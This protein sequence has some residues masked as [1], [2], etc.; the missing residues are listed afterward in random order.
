MGIIGCSIWSSLFKLSWHTTQCTTES[1]QLSDLTFGFDYENHL[2]SR[3]KVQYVSVTYG[4]FYYNN[5]ESRIEN[6]IELYS[7]D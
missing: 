1:L 5:T 3:D 2:L 4:S 7:G 6:N